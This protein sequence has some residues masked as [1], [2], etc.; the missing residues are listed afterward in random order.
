[1]FN[2]VTAWLA[3]GICCI[4]M[5]SGLPAQVEEPLIRTAIRGDSVYVYQTTQFRIGHGMNVYRQDPGETEFR[6]LNES[7]VRGVQYASELPVQLRDVYEEVRQN[8]GAENPRDMLM[9]FRTDRVTS[10]LYTFFFPEVARALG[11]LYIDGTAPVGE[12]V[13]YL[14]ELVDD[15]GRPL[16]SLRKSV[17]LQMPPL[18][19]PADL[20]AGN[21]GRQVTLKWSYP[22]T[23]LENDDKIIEFNVYRELEGDRVEQMN[24]GIIL[25]NNAKSRFS[26]RFTVPQ[27]GRQE[28][29]FVTAET[30]NEL[31]T[32]PGERLDYYVEDNVPPQ[33]VRNV[34][35]NTVEGGVEVTWGVSPELDVQG[36]II[37]R[38]PR[39]GQDSTRLNKELI[40]SMESVYLDTTVE[41]RE[42]Y[43]Y[44]IVAVDSAGNESGI[45]VAGHVRVTDRTP[46]GPVEDVTAEY[47]EEEVVEVRWDDPTPASDLRSYYVMRRR[48]M[49]DE[50]RSFN[51]LNQTDMRQT[52]YIDSGV[53]EQPFPEGATF[54]YM[55][56]AVDSVYN[57]SDSTFTTLQIPDSTKPAPPNNLVAS[58]DEGLRVNLTWN[59]STSADVVEY[60]I[61]RQPSDTAADAPVRRVPSTTRLIRDEEVSV[62]TRYIYRV[63]AVDSFENESDK[64]PADT[65]LV[66]EFDPPR[67]VRN[68]RV[69]T[70][71]T[72]YRISWEMVPDEDVTGYKVYRSDLATGVYEPLT[73]E[74]LSDSSW[75]DAGG[76]SGLWY[77]VRA[78]DSSGNLSK[79][80]DPVQAP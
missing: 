64:S 67:V 14:V 23:T 16:D 7:P 17:T 21:E 73:S 35:A 20:S 13:T 42:R 59:T 80:S 2:R 70:A 58:N 45:S 24:D 29:F 19:P 34:Q 5:T 43:V 37:Y 63:S 15:R 3:V 22:K 52:A 74:P 76:E 31:E 11:R 1:M 75:I 32:A 77:Y 8:M 62:G 49:N 9:T 79:P 50:D 25:R 44:Q 57:Y 36:Y 30:I 54:Q 46:P 39:L 65:V 4:L 41:E 51:R 27:T 56:I 61:Y 66:R 68:V 78:V 18:E 12:E 55:V 40:P 53:A 48:L 69:D 60:N 47:L 71:E 33:V 72:G 28:T 10:G 6:Q 26:F 38:R